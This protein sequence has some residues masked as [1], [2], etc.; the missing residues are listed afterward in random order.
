MKGYE[1][2][3]STPGGEDNIRTVTQAVR[4][5]REEVEIDEVYESHIYDEGE[6]IGLLITTESDIDEQEIVD[7]SYMI[8]SA[9]FV[10]MD[11]GIE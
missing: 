7:K 6:G 2:I 8:E 5:L 9:Q 11:F 10:P 4:T 3:V 1:F